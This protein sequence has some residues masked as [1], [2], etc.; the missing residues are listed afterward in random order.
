MQQGAGTCNLYF[1]LFRICAGNKTKEGTYVHVCITVQLLMHSPCV[2][3]INIEQQVTNQMIV[4]THVH[5]ILHVFQCIYLLR[6]GVMLYYHPKL[7]CVYIT[8][9]IL[10][11][12]CHCHP[13]IQWCYMKPFLHNSVCSVVLIFVLAN[14]QSICVCSLWGICF[15]IC[16]LQ[17]HPSGGIHTEYPLTVMPE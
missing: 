3:F 15:V 6:E 8:P 4:R 1:L 5:T 7:V 12:L 9:V 10:K 13:C 16:Q 2:Y 17:G 14:A 11:Q